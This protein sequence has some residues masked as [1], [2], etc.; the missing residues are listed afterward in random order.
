MWGVNG[1][2]GKPVISITT[3]SFRLLQLN[4]QEFTG[5]SVPSYWLQRANDSR[6]FSTMMCEL[7]D[8]VPGDGDGGRRRGTQKTAVIT[9]A[10]M[11]C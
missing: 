9:A 4:S 6:G 2:R 5:L 7:A 10:A 11:L 8:A 3:P 1:V